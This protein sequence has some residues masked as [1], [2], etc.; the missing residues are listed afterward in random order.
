M[1]RG[2]RAGHQKN[3]TRE[4][5]NKAQGS[6]FTGAIDKQVAESVAKMLGDIPVVKSS[7]RTLR[8][9]KTDC[10]E[11]GGVRI[12]GGIR[13]Q[14]FDV[15]YRPDGPRIAYDSKTLNDLKSV[16]K[17]WQNMVNDL[18]TEAA[19]VHTRFPYA[20]VAFA[21]TIPGPALGE[22]QR[23]DIIRTLDRLSRR[24]DVM[25]QAHLAEVISLIVW[26]PDTG[27]IDPDIP[28]ADSR[29]RIERFAKLLYP[30]YKERYKGLPP[31]EHGAEKEQSDGDEEDDDE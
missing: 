16:G 12:V 13:P 8:P 15:V 30:R 25:D 18:A 9:A 1:A 27:A 31:H 4:R 7:G 5:F 11:W 2:H 24:A 26:D 28:S 19:T 6:R 22:R 10:V 29:L 3:K 17:N 20:V 23:A 14:N 21:V